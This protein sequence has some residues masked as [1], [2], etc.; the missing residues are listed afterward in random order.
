MNKTI[1]YN[2]G[3][4]IPAEADLTTKISIPT[5]NVYQTAFYYVYKEGITANDVNINTEKTY[6]YNGDT[7]FQANSSDILFKTA[8]EYTV[9]FATVKTDAYGNL[10]LKDEKPQIVKTSGVLTINKILYKQL[11]VFI[12]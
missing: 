10:I 6:E 12:T 9:I 2:G 11:E 1:V 7:Y 5:N 8:G 4:Q 3:V